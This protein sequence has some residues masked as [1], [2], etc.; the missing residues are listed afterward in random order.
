MGA[1]EG[2]R[3]R[4]T[5]C[6]AVRALQSIERGRGRARRIHPAREVVRSR[7]RAPG[8][9]VCPGER[10]NLPR[11]QYNTLHFTPMARHG[12]TPGVKQN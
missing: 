11:L 7:A 1:W 8:F 10:V 12:H 4:L 3:W 5:P 2:A 6:H 9:P